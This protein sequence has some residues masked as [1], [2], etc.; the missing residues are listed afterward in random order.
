METEDVT[1]KKESEVKEEPKEDSKQN[2]GATKDAAKEVKT[3]V[4]TEKVESAAAATGNATGMLNGGLSDSDGDDAV[5]PNT[6]ACFKCAE[7]CT[8][9]AFLQ[10][11]SICPLFTC[12]YT[13]SVGRQVLAVLC[14]Q[15]LVSVSAPAPPAV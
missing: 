10:C 13:V 1:D 12:L 3:E 8:T 14:Q 6:V 9:N 7:D 11:S 2:K 4:K 5:S 15:Q